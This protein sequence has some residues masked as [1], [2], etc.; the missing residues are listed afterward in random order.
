MRQQNHQRSKLILQKSLFL[1]SEVES[2]PK[3]LNLVVL[4][5]FEVKRHIAPHLKALTSGIEV[6]M[7]M[8]VLLSCTTL[9]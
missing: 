3:S 1:F 4:I 7:S 5:P 6:I 8:A 2:L 9:A